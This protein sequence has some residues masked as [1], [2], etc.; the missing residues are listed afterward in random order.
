[1]DAK[2]QSILEVV[3]VLPF[4][5][6]LVGLMFKM[7]LGIQMAINNVQYARSQVFV[8][9]ANSPEYPRLQFRMKY[10]GSSGKLSVRQH[11]LMLLGVSR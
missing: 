1:M 2:G 3:A 9:T 7:N 5:F 10:A 4:L 8:L 6:I 11:D